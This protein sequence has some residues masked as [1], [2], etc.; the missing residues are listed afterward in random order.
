MIHAGC[1]QCVEYSRYQTMTKILSLS[2]LRIKTRRK[3][4]VMMVTPALF[5][6]C[7]FLAIFLFDNRVRLSGVPDKHRD[8]LPTTVHRFL[9]CSMAQYLRRLHSMEDRQEYIYR[10]EREPFAQIRVCS[11]AFLETWTS[12]WAIL[13]QRTCNCTI[14]FF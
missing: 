6:L 13:S 12:A 4:I 5:Q 2:S 14:I 11:V 1:S 7:Q 3:V 10:V 9:Y 8:T